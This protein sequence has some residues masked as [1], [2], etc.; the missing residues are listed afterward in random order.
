MARAAVWRLDSSAGTEFR[1]A[2]QIVRG[3][4]Q[5]RGEAGAFYAAIAG[6]TEVTDGLHPAE[7]L[8]DPLA[9]ALADRVTGPAGGAQVERRAARAPLILLLSVPKTPSEPDLRSSRELLSK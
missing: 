4:D 3:A 6:A 8:L 7:D 2:Q 5:V 1:D 9:N